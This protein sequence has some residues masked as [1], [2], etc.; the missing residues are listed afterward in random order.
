MEKFGIRTGQITAE[1]RLGRREQARAHANFRVAVRKESR[2][3]TT[4]ANPHEG[5]EVRRL[6]R[7]SSMR[8]EDFFVRMRFSFRLFS[9]VVLVLLIAG[10]ASQSRAQSYLKN[11][12]VSVGVFG[13]FSP[14]TS[15]NGITDTPTVSVG[16]QAAFRH[17]YH[18]W[19][20]YEGSYDYTRYAER[21]S[22]LPYTVQHNTHEFA[23]SYLIT[24]P[25]LLG[26]H[27]F[28]F[29]GISA[30]VFSPTLNGGQNVSWQGEPAANF[31]GGINWALLSSHFGLRLQYRGVYYKT[32]DFNQA[33]LNTG[34]SRLT[35]EPMAG[36]YLRF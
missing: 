19:L 9:Y 1:L 30:L 22:V 28:V 14:R 32:P 26:L 24:T 2:R 18:W 21:Y 10:F 25:G 6:S 16:G 33:R 17:S 23:A 3:G 31:G 7:L 15:G 12:D 27:P 11:S 4:K 36:V 5:R 20:G 35:S 8:E 34:T 13:Q 29:G